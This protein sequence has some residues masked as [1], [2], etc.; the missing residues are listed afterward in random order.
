MKIKEL[1]I[2]NILSFQYFENISDATKIVFDGDLNIFIGENGAGKSTAL[3][4]INFIFKKVLFTQFNVNQDLY[5]RK[6]TLTGTDR[7]QILLPG[8]NKTYSGLRL[9]P[10]WDTENSPQKIRLVLQLDEIDTANINHLIAHKD[11]IYTLASSYTSHSTTPAMA[12]QNEYAIEITL[13]KNDKTFTSS[14]APDN[15]P[16]YLYLVNYNFYKELINFYN[17]ENPRNLIA[18]LYESFTLIG[19]YRN[20]HSFNPSVSLQNS[21]A[22]LQIQGI[23]TQ[24]YSKSLNTSEQAEPTIFNLVRLRV[25]AKHY[26]LY[27]EESKGADCEE[28]ANN[29]EFLTKINSRLTLVNLEVK[30]QFTG[31]QRWEYSFQFFDIKRKQPLNDINSL[32]AGQKAII[33]LVFEAYGRGDLKGGLVIIDEPEIHLHY[34]FQNEYLHV[35]NEINKEQHCQYVL[36]THSESLINSTTIHNVKRFALNQNNYTVIKFPSLSTD[37]KT[38]IKILDNTRSTYAFFAKK[39][40]LIEGET[41][42]YFFKAL[43]Q[44]LK[45]ELTQEIAVLDIIGKPNQKIWRDFFEAFG[46]TVYFVGDLDAAYGILYADNPAPK[47]CTLELVNNFKT[48]HPTLV[49]DIESKYLDKICILKNGDLDYYLGIHNK[50]L[51]ETIKFCNENLKDYLADDANEQS[52]ELRFIFNELT[53]N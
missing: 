38:L 50:G 16:G 14:I 3:E 9:E 29:Q 1:Q 48:A 18:P 8:N 19:G 5:S 13:N 51:S 47:L 17:Y 41:D 20:Y 53:K 39:V 22:A 10:N 31:K 43:I 46:L 15:D 7:K 27:G 33:H 26:E 28:K 37:Q 25:A 49:A 35:I 52:K 30:I 34:Q 45:P 40:L 12:L 23:R 21:T 44:E 2:S 32:S 6:S 42:R 4:V 36:V 24:E 11:K